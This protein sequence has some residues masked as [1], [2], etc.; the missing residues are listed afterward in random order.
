MS[1]S[2]EQTR[3]AACE[4]SIK[5]RRAAQSISDAAAY[6]FGAF[7]GTNPAWRRKALGSIAE[8]RTILDQAE[9]LLTPPTEPLSAASEEAA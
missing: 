3:D 1:I 9:T 5:L 2:D 4:A 6:A 8:A 7:A